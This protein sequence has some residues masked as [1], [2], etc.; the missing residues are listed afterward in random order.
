M[1]DNNKITEESNYTDLLKK[2][3]EKGCRRATR[4]SVT[5]SLFGEHISFDISDRF[6]LLTTKKMYWR[7]IVE[8]LLWFLRG[9]TDSKRLEARRVNIWKGNS[10][11]EFIEKRGLA[12]REG[13]CGPVYGF[14]WL[15][16]NARYEGCDAN[17]DGKG[18]NQLQYCIDLIKKDPTSRRILMTGWNPEQNDQMVLPPCHVS[19]QFY[20]HD[21]RLSCL[22]YQRSA[23][24]F[25]GLPF[26]IASTA[27]LVYIIA[28]ECDLIPGQ[29]NI[30][31]GDAHIYEG[32]MEQ[33]KRQLS[34]SFLA[35]PKL[36]F[37]KK[38]IDEYHYEDFKLIDYVSHPS[39]KA[40]MV[41]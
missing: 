34:N 30:T 12:Y 38:K 3:M 24:L 19:Y 1:T 31:I 25:L 16:W 4:N 6:P 35:F 26:N 8:E 36:E 39:I 21:G 28:K 41:A 14:Q 10:T 23:D 11:E 15:H 32:H 7:G 9:D 17:Y 5:Q 18:V 2:V 22:M 40:E 29:I 33:V 13:D 20:V 27:L 37:N